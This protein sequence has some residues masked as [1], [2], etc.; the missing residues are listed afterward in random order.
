MLTK[1]SEASHESSLFN[2]GASYLVA[3]HNLTF[4]KNA[5]DA[6]AQNRSNVIESIQ[7]ILTKHKFEEAKKKKNMSTD[8]LADGK[9]Q[10]R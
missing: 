5:V 8:E 1:P 2:R 6:N 3:P 10:K 4:N 9:K 7:T